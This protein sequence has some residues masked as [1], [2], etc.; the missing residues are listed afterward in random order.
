MLF[1]VVAKKIMSISC[2]SNSSKTSDQ[3]KTFTVFGQRSFSELLQIL[4]SKKQFQ[5]K[6]VKRPDKST[7]GY[8]MLDCESYIKNL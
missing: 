1:K 4:L 8:D 2:K 6:G 5:E 3:T 7:T